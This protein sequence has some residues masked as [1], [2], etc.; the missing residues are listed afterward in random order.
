MWSWNQFKNLPRNRDLSPGEQSRQ[1]FIYQSNMMYEA[2][3]NN[4]VAAA[5]AASAAGAGS[6][7]GSL[8]KRSRAIKIAAKNN[9]IGYFDQGDTQNLVFFTADW[10]AKSF[11]NNADTGIPYD[12][13]NDWYFDEMIDGKGVLFRV[14]MNND[15]VYYIFVDAGG[16]IIET[17]HLIYDSTYGTSANRRSCEGLVIQL[18]YRNETGRIIKWWNGDEIFTHT[19]T[20]INS[21]SNNFSLDYYGYDDAFSDGT[22]S[23]AINDTDLGYR[24]FHCRPD[25]Q[26]LE[27]TSSYYI[28]G[29]APD[30]DY[31][32]CVGDFAIFTYQFNSPTLGGTASYF[33]NSYEVTLSAPIPGLRVGMEITGDDFNAITTYITSIAP[34]GTSFTI[35][36]YP[37]GNNTNEPITFNGYFIDTIRVMKADG[38]Y[39]DFDVSEYNANYIEN[40]ELI[41]SDKALFMLYRNFNSSVVYTMYNHTTKAITT[42]SPI[43]YDNGYSWINRENKYLFGYVPSIV[44]C[45]KFLGAHYGNSNWDGTMNQFTSLTFVWTDSIGNFYDYSFAEAINNNEDNVGWR[46]EYDLGGTLYQIINSPGSNNVE[47]IRFNDNGTVDIT[48]LGTTYSNS[49]DYFNLSS[50]GDKTLITWYDN[51]RNIAP[52]YKRQAFAVFTGGTSS[53]DQI[54]V[55]TNNGWNTIGKTFITGQFTEDKTYLFNYTLNQFYSIND[56]YTGYNEF[57]YNSYQDRIDFEELSNISLNFSGNNYALVNTNYTPPFITEDGVAAQ[58]FRGNYDYAVKLVNDDVDG[59]TRIDVY[60]FEGTVVNSVLTQTSGWGEFEVV[61]D[62]IFLLQSLGS[63]IYHLYLVTY[64]SFEFKEMNAYNGYRMLIND[65]VNWD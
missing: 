39:T 28:N 16:N 2:S 26:F 50:L 56:I 52:D 6:G 46:S 45:E 14:N 22:T 47:I 24:V 15:D 65:W 41:G 5:A 53:V 1:Y 33:N 42:S 23:A 48:S 20:T 3:V 36:D 49:G 11:S 9:T 57:R 43:D 62:R 30:N 61:G 55:D 10:D 59:Y 21:G 29:T 35:S 7:G 58:D 13:I 37:S 60:D 44:G 51:S 38:S 18:S 4:T 8:K 12:D 34:G 31:L 19:D 32:F 63:D 54:W 25:G 17:V 64:D 40:D 27:V